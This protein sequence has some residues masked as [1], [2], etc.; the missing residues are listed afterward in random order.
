MGGIDKLAADARRPPAAGLDAGGASRGSPASAGSSWSPRADRVDELAGRAPGCRP[1]VVG[2]RRRRRAPPGLR[3]GGCRGARARTGRTTT[4]SSSSTTARGRWSA[5]ILVERSP[6]P[7]REHGAAIPVLPVAET[8]KR[9]DGERRRRDRRPRR[10]RRRA[11]AAGRAGA[12][13]SARRTPG[14]RPTGQRPGPTRPPCWRPVPSRSM[15]S[16]ATRQPQGDAARRPRPRR[17]RCSAADRPTRR[18]SAMT[19]P[20]RAGRRRS[21]SAASRFAGAPRLYGHS[22]GDVAL[23]AV[24]DALLGAAGLGDLG[25]LFPAAT[26]RRAGSPARTCSP[27]SSTGL[28]AAGWRPTRVDVTI[29]AAR[30]RLGRAARR[31]CATRSP[32]LLGHRRRRRSTSRRRPATSTEP[33]AP[34]ASISAL[35]DRHAC[36]R[37]R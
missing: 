10:A 5:P 26:G 3:R 6:R 9:V 1:D 27:R 21:R 25:R 7:P 22:D 24:A 11:D 8:L 37:V 35:G 29:V 15:P 23:H 12:A 14:S 31:R 17:R 20:V 36:E 16:P 18:V 34:A 28:E 13:C 30:P 32:S 2:R 33:R 4:G 19:P